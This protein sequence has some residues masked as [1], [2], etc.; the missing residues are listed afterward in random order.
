MKVS[1]PVV[2][3]AVAALVTALIISLPVFAAPTAEQKRLAAMATDTE[4]FKKEQADQARRNA[5]QDKEAKGPKYQQDEFTRL[6]KLRP[7]MT[8]AEIEDCKKAFK[9]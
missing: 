1:K 2:L 6:C 3:A 9:L 5:A 8:D 4:V 7:V